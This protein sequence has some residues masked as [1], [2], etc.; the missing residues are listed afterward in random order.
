MKEG[1]GRVR[2]RRMFKEERQGEKE[3]WKGTDEG[4]RGKKEKEGES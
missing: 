1:M 3:E 4:K 2:V